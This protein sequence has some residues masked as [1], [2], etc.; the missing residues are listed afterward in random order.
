MFKA[1]FCVKGIIDNLPS[2]LTERLMDGTTDD[3][4]GMNRGSLL[5]FLKKVQ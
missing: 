2:L 4:G 1:F 3:R 5:L